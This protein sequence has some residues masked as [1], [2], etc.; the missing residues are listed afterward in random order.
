MSID[1]AE[2]YGSALRRVL[3]YAERFKDSAM[4]RGLRCLK[5]EGSRSSASLRR[6]TSADQR[7]VPVPLAVPALLAV[8]VT[9]RLRFDCSVMASG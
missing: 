6:V 3:R 4:A 5:T 9:L 7:F 1:S 8:L 2:R